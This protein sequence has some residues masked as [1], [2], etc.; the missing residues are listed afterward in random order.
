MKFDV[1]KKLVIH[2]GNTNHMYKYKM[3]RKFISHIAEEKDLED[4]LYVMR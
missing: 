4:P 1:K 3:F 2:I